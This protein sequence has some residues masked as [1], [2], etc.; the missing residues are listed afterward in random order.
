[1]ELSENGDMTIKNTCLVLALKSLKLSEKLSNH[2]GAVHFWGNDVLNFIILNKRASIFCFNFFSSIFQRDADLEV[3][4]TS[5]TGRSS[6]RATR[7]SP[8]PGPRAAGGRCE[9]HLMGT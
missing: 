4:A 8:G 3:G 2:E 6:G 5:R 9:G 1:V 7:G